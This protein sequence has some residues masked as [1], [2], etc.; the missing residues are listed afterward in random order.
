GRGV[1]EHELIALLVE[2]LKLPA[3]DLGF[4]DPVA[5]AEALVELAAVE[6]VLQLDLV[7]GRPLA[8]LHRSGLDRGPERAVV[9][10]HHAGPDIAAADLGHA[11]RCPD[12]GTSVK[13]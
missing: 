5:A 8:G 12:A 13:A 6:D 4:L 2:K 7:V 9:L 1:H 3:L 11:R 10:D